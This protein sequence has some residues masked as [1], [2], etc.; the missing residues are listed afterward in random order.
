MK[1]DFNLLLKF[2]MTSF[3][4]EPGFALAKLGDIL[5]VTPLGLVTVNA[6]KFALFCE[7]VVAAAVSVIFSISSISVT[8]AEYLVRFVEPKP[9]AVVCSVDDLFT[10][11]VPRSCVLP[12]LDICKHHPAAGPHY[13]KNFVFLF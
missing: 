4:A 3:L 11:A 13:W 10:C 8:E 12:N 2:L 9:V 7:F 5:L 1:H 6:E